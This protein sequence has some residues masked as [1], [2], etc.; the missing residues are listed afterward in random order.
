VFVYYRDDGRFPAAPGDGIPAAAL[1]DTATGTLLSGLDPLKPYAFTAFVLDTAGNYSA[2]SASARA[3][4]NRTP[5]ADAGRDTVLP[6]TGRTSLR[7]DGTRS[8]DAEGGIRSFSWSGV[9]TNPE[10]VVVEDS[11]R[12][13]IELTKP[14]QYVFVLT[15]FDGEKVSRPSQVRVTLLAP[16]VVVSKTLEPGPYRLY[17]TLREGLAAAAPGDTIFVDRGIYSENDTARVPRLYIFS[18]DATAIINGENLGC[19]LTLEGDAVEGIR[20]RNLRFIQGGQDRPQPPDRRG[21][22]AGQGR[23]EHPVRELLVR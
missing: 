10:E 3:A 15:V 16:D 20:I 17:R 19:G 4:V 8:F 21:R 22:P 13:L 2:P 5:N 14:G 9:K 1:G 7:L 11:S 6:F 12:P 18:A 23:Q